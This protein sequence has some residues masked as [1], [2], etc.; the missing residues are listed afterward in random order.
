MSCYTNMLLALI[1]TT[2]TLEHAEGA[3]KS[4]GEGENH[5]EEPKVFI[6]RVPDTSL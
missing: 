2:W 5:Q 4:R 3:G 1:L 6:Q